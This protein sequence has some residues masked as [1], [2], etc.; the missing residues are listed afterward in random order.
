[1]VESSTVPNESVTTKG[2]KGTGEDGMPWQY[3]ETPVI[4]GAGGGGISSASVVALSIQPNGVVVTT[5]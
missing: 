3:R 1:M 2:T 5:V 4:T